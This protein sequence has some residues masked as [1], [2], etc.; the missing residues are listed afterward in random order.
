MISI[1]YASSGKPYTEVE[2]NF[3]NPK[4]HAWAVDIEKHWNE[5]KGEVGKFIEKYDKSFTSNAERYKGL[6]KAEWSSLTFSFW[7][8]KVKGGLEKECPLLAAYLNEI[9]GLV[10]VSFSRIGPQ[11]VIDEHRGDT[12]AAFRCHLGIEVPEGLPNCGFMVS[13]EQKAWEEGK[14]LFFN[15]AQR[16]SAWNKTDKR[17]IL[18]ILDVIRPEFLNQ[19]KMICARLIARHS[20][21]QR[22]YLEKLPRPIK[23]IVFNLTALAIRLYMLF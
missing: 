5:I 16:H 14:W 23:N 19:Q 13:G 3:Y 8:I 2:P 12:N 17:R 1:W 21:N 10:S 18:L 20:I 11:S 4:E 22:P 6:E 7:G 9:P 15:D